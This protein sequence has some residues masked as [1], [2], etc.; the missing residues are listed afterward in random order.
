MEKV[1]KRWQK[2]CNESSIIAKNCKCFQQIE[3]LKTKIEDEDDDGDDDD[4]GEEEFFSFFSKFRCFRLEL[5]EQINKCT[6]STTKKLIARVPV[7]VVFG[8][9]SQSISTSRRRQPVMHQRSKESKDIVLEF[10]YDHL[11]VNAG[12]IFFSLRYKVQKSHIPHA[13]RF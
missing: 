6:I 10:F 13:G 9:Q 11:V 1:L 12:T 2:S 7:E 8:S 3:K 4:D 5:C